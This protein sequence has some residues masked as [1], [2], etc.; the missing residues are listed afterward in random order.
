M[1]PNLPEEFP[2]TS[3]TATA[4]SAYTAVDSSYAPKRKPSRRDYNYNKQDSNHSNNTHQE[5]NNNRKKGTNDTIAKDITFNN[6]SNTNNSNSNHTAAEFGNLQQLSQP[7]ATAAITPTPLTYSPRHR[8]NTINK[9]GGTVFGAAIQ[10]EKT[11]NGNSNSKQLP[12]TLPPPSSPNSSSLKS[13]RDLFVTVEDDST[14]DIT[15]SF[16]S[17]PDTSIPKP[18]LNMS[19]PGLLVLLT[20]AIALFSSSVNTS[21]LSLFFSSITSQ[22][23]MFFSSF[24]SFQS[25]KTIRF[26]FL[27]ILWYASSA[28]TNNIG[29][30]LLNAFP[31]PVTLTWI[32][33][34]FVS[35][36]CHILGR[37]GFTRIRRL[38]VEILRETVPLSGFQIVGHGF[39]S[40]ATSQVP[41]SF[42]H[43]IKALSPLFTVTFYRIIFA[44]TYSS[45]VYFSLIPLTIGVMLACSVTTSSSFIG[46]LFAM[47][48]TVIFV[49]Q[50]VFSKTL[51]RRP[52]MPGEE[53]L[54]KLNLMFF[55]STIAFVLMVPIWAWYEGF[56]FGGFLLWGGD[57]GVSASVSAWTILFYF[58]LNGTTHFFQN[59]LAFNI[60][61]I[62]SPVTYSIA[63]LVKRIFV[64][65]A[66]IIWFGQKT[67]FIQGVGILLTFI[68]L[69]LYNRAKGD[70]DKKERKVANGG[71]R[72][73][74]TRMRSK[75]IK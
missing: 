63:S 15:R 44:V 66:S 1:P 7:M 48:S 49:A 27:C 19:S 61:E 58:F 46:F 2:T 47:G 34:G 21:Q 56:A 4:T 12:P 73:P 8:S 17:F 71:E 25:I 22:L 35:L 24:T 13:N 62:T 55:S 67:T 69:H 39:S 33:F 20:Q 36:Y 68:G 26:I 43:T 60:L 57:L 50:N 70:V 40:V 3:A 37:L 31:Y 54:D 28:I 16:I 30:S 41:V 18:T 59:T 75:S 14:P 10:H 6:T 45:A 38:T 23:S 52:D 11:G 53:K 29:K 9:Y 51:L 5:T 42:V 32:Q 64:I 65:T 74:M 72:L